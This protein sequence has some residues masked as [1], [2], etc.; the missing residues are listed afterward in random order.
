MII[1]TY[2]MMNYLQHQSDDEK[3]IQ[4]TIFFSPDPFIV[5]VRVLKRYNVGVL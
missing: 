2:I 3:K 4:D 5:T 1:S